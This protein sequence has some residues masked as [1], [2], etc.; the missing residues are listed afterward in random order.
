MIKELVVQGEECRAHLK[1]C[2]RSRVATDRSVIYRD[3][4]DR[5]WLV[6]EEGGSMRLLTW[7]DLQLNYPEVLD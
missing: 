5:Y 3:S 2:E 1:K 7:N 6:D 4:V